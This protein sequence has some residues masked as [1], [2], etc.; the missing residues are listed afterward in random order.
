MLT[1]EAVTALDFL[2]RQAFLGAVISAAVGADHVRTVLAAECEQAIVTLLPDEL[3]LG[4]EGMT[5]D[6]VG[7][8][9]DGV[10]ASPSCYVLLE[11]KRIRRS[12]FQP[13]QLAREYVAVLQHAGDKLPLLLLLLGEP[14]PVPVKGLGRLSIADAVGVGLDSTLERT[15]DDPGRRPSLLAALPDVVAW[16]T[17]HELASV[18]SA[19]RARYQSPDPSVDAC[20]GRLVESLLAAVNRHS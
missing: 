19:Q 4:T 14:P 20:V 7:V 13:E 18:V 11:A 8:Q 2:P 15:G 5:S 17:W 6:R 3:S 9:P 10:V 1:A 12:S 16:I